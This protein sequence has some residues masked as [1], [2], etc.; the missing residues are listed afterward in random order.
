METVAEKDRSG[1][2]RIFS[3]STKLFAAYG[4][5]G[6]STRQIAAETGLSVSTVHH[7]AGSKRGLYLRI[8]ENLYE[9]EEELVET[10]LD[11]IDDEVI[12]DRERFLKVL[13]QL[14][15]RLLE[16]A[17]ENPERQR[18]YVMRWLAPPD[19]LRDREADLTLRLYH[20][21]AAILTR[22][23]QFGMIRGDLNL[24]YFIRSFDWLIFSY[25]VSGA[26]NWQQLR[27][28]PLCSENLEEFKQYLF[29]YVRQMLDL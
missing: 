10:I 5:E 15:E 7:H 17:Q 1:R 8:I 18:L 12:K 23:Q 29:D 27:A 21:L 19:E 16:F 28:D 13:D 14:L 4:Y 11:A 3:E 20:R 6:V 22:G 25:F 24:G 2:D 9:K 26:F